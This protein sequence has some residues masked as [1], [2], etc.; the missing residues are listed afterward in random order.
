VRGVE[1]AD[2]LVGQV[3]DVLIVAGVGQE[4]LVGLPDRFP[5]R[6]V[7]LG[8][9]E[10][11]FHDPPAFLEDLLELLAL[12]DD[13]LEP[14]PDLLLF[15]VREFHLEQA[16]LL[17]VEDRLAVLGDLQSAERPVGDLLAV[18]AVEADREDP[19]ALV[20]R[21][22]EIDGLAVLGKEEDVP[23]AVRP[24][25]QLDGAG[26][27][28]EVDPERGSGRRRRRGGALFLLGLRLLGSLEAL[29]DQRIVGVLGQLG[30]RDLEQMVHAGVPVAQEEQGLPVGCQLAARVA[31]GIRGDVE[32]F[33]PGDIEEM[34]VGAGPASRSVRRAISVGENSPD[35]PPGLEEVLDAPG[36]D[37]DEEG[38]LAALKAIF[39]ESLTR[40]TG[41]WST[42]GPVSFFRRPSRGPEPDL[43]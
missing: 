1:L 24:R 15:L 34:D 18:L 20:V 23:D 32:S 35:C 33:A 3:V 29:P 26:R 30:Q 36:L 38:L 19:R 40:R 6:A 43:L 31:E 10:A 22:Q 4:R 14:E 11:V 9:V 37:V 16:V 8:I 42:R 13:D 41:P 28:P 12:V 5:V 25:G 7:H 39:F 21:A 17:A 27:C 2:G